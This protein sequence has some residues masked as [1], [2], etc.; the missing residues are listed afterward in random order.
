[1]IGTVR[2]ATTA[3]VT[4]IVET[5]TDVFHDDPTWSFVFQDPV[6]RPRQYRRWWRLFA[7]GAVRHEATWL[8]DD[9]A[10]VAM[11]IPPGGTELSDEQAAGLEP[12]LHELLG[13]RAELVLAALESFEA[14]HPRD[15]PHYYLTMLGTRGD[16]RGK[17]LGMALLRYCLDAVDSEGVAAYLESSNPANNHRYESVGFVPLGQFSM[18]EGGP[19]VTTMWRPRR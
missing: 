19:T 16:S 9:G 10:A 1:M 14:A 2:L 17:G 5:L 13:S 8:A 15:E 4:A 12:L 3:D 7:E 18:P 6:A 11:W